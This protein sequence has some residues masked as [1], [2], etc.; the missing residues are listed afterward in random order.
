MPK[1]YGR[2]LRIAE[3]IQ[4]IAAPCVAALAREHRWGMVTI[5]AVDVAADMT[6]A[7]LF[8]SVMGHPD[9]AQ[10]MA[11]LRD[12]LPEIRTAVARDLPLKK[13]PTLHV[14]EDKSIAQGARIAELLRPG[15]TGRE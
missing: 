15:Q 4:R 2:N 8:I 11:G 3:A 14:A 5:T 10:V 7:R 9:P 12:A 6:V 13:V 1:E